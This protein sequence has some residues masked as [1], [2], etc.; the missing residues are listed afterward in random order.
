MTKALVPGES[1]GAI[2]STLVQS[3]AV[4]WDTATPA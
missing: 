1:Q 4:A 2:G 3:G